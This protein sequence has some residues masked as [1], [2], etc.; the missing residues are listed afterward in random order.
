[1][2][3]KF[4]MTALA[5]AMLFSACSKEEVDNSTTT[6]TVKVE[7]A[8]SRAIQAPGTTNPITLANGVI[9]LLAPDGTVN[10]ATALNPSQVMGSGQVFT[11]VPSS[12][13]VFIVANAPAAAQTAL[14]AATS[15]ADIQAVTTD[16]LGY[17]STLYSNVALSNADGYPAHITIVNPATATVNVSI[18]PVI[19][20]LELAGITGGEY[21][22]PA[23]TQ[24]MTRIVGF[25]VLGVFLDSYFPEFTYTGGG[26]GTL[27]EINQT[28]VANPAVTWTGI[29]DRP[30]APATAWTASG[31]PPIAIP[32]AGQVWGYNVPATTLSPLVI[33]VHIVTYETSTDGGTT[34]VAGSGSYMGI[35]YITVSG[36]N[37]TI[38]GNTGLATQF[39]RGH[40]Y[41]IP[42]SG[43]VFTTNNLHETPNPVDV[44]LTVNVT[45]QNWTLVPTTTILE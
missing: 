5:A 16:A 38:G 26:Y 22:D 14:L 43:L 1:M 36:F 31:T 19:A 32:G 45:I 10:S 21:T 11:G 18:S 6:L 40:I 20:R 13:R 2:K 15:F 44:D 39:D 4:F 7:A 42:A 9:F 12:S 34:W 23:N 17:Q 25:E 33:A 28:E 29:Q 37:V 27:V 8:A 35:Q 24:N 30:T 41:Q 3:S